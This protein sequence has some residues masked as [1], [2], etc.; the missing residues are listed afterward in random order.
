MSLRSADFN[1]Q[2]AG[3][4]H[5]QRPLY[6]YCLNPPKPTDCFLGWSPTAPSGARV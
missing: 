3:R 1:S 2:W 6:L 5:V 4:S